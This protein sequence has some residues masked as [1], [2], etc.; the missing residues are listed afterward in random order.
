M[1]LQPIVLI[2]V[3]RSKLLSHNVCVCIVLAT[4]NIDLA[5]FIVK[6]YAIN[7]MCPCQ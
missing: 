6:H 4:I 5:R 1:S 2:A 7:T 3:H